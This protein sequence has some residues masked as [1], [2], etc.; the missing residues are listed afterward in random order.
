METPE[1]TLGPLVKRTKP[2]TMQI[3]A[4]EIYSIEGFIPKGM[5]YTSKGVCMWVSVDGDLYEIELKKIGP[6]EAMSA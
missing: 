2:T 5:A 6:V 1:V 3:M 4:S